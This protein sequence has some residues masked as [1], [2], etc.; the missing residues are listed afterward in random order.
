M[1]VPQTITQKI[2]AA[3][4]GREFV[5]AGE[6]INV[7][8][9]VMLAN[10]ITAPLALKEFAKI[11]CERVRFPE[12]VALV[13]DHFVPAKDIRAAQQAKLLKEFAQEQK[14]PNYW[15]IGRGGIEHTLLPDEGVVVSGDCVIG[16]DSHTC[17][18]GAL[19][20]FA[21]G[22]GSTDF[23]AA[24][25]TGECWLRVPESIKFIYRGQLRPWV[26]GKDLIL[27][28]IGQIGVDGALYQAMEFCGEA[29]SALDMAGRFTMCNMAIE[30]G[31][32]SGIIAPD[33][34]TLAYE[35]ARAKRPPKGYTS[36]GSAPYTRTMEF[37]CGKIEPQVAFPHLP[38][39]SRPVSQVGNVA[40]DQAVI[41][42]C[43][44]GRLE[45][46]RQAAEILR[47]R[48]VHPR[49]RLIVIP[50]TQ[51]IHLAA[52][53][54]GLAQV[55]LEAGGVFSPPTCGPCLGGHMGIL[56]EGER[57]IATT[58]RNFIGRMGDKKSEVYLANPAI[59]AASAVLGR[60]GSPED[61]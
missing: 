35:K 44:N 36:D 32:K 52:V 4:C 48:K 33:E 5:E 54:E 61:I 42:S 26:G 31:G 28:T 16:A 21:T 11:G 38:S 45:D 12:K 50:A 17:T 41:G 56:A 51:E 10:D 49:V 23:A 9:D 15:E 3:H 57:A 59:A 46:L 29:I 7:Q 39:N 14:I 22:V 24:L 34:T 8:L 25:A 18:Y 40:I 58:N 2:L 53:K 47:G 19:G 13:P 6:F 43:T 1:P 27:Y 20:A 37:D 55:F 60:I 30:A